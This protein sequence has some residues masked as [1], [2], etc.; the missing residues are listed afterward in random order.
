M[1]ATV[2]SYKTAQN[3]ALKHISNILIAAFKPVV[4]N[5]G[6]FPISVDDHME[7]IRYVDAMHVR[8]N[9]QY[10]YPPYLYTENEADIMGRLIQDVSQ[11]TKQEFNISKKP[12]MSSLSAISLFRV[13]SLLQDFYKKDFSI[14]EIG[15]GCGYLGALLLKSGFNY[16]SMDNT[17]AFYLWQ[18]LLYDYIAG[19]QC[20]DFAATEYDEKCFTS[21][22]LHIPWWV[23]CNFH[24]MDTIKRDIIVCDHALSEISKNALKFILN[25]S[26]KMLDGDGMK[27]FIFDSPGATVI[28]SLSD[29]FNEF[30][31][32]GFVP[33][34]VPQCFCFTPKGSE[35]SKYACDNDL[36]LKNSLLQKVKRRI[37]KSKD[38]SIFEIFDKA[39]SMG[40]LNAYDFMKFTKEELPLD[41]EP[42]SF[43]GYKIP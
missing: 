42:L 15:A 6:N 24:K 5:M 27:L 19:D 43:I 30:S 3:E 29:L 1:K 26:R 39:K 34:L 10:F 16:A 11:L 25:V 4:F 28:S 38:N 12:L 37:D 8:K 14:F 18:S 17:Q 2:S 9:A 40:S 36:I 7:L 31:K 32:A 21:R 41:Y 23:Y 13:I 33:I 35:L 22:C 20:V